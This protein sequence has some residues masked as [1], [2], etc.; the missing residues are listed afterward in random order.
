MIGD[1][2]E[3][4][5]VQAGESSSFPPFLF[6]FDLIMRRVDFIKQIIYGAFT[7]KKSGLTQFDCI[8]RLIRLS[9]F[10]IKRLLL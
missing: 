4:L 3:I 7:Y 2:L 6:N 10:F 5:N 9:K 8:S 1:I